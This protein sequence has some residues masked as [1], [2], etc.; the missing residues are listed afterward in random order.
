METPIQFDIPEDLVGDEVEYCFR[1]VLRDVQGV[2]VGM[3]YI[4][5]S[6]TLGVH[7]QQGLQ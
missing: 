6:L 3:Y 7:A 5:M 4:V 1:V 2:V